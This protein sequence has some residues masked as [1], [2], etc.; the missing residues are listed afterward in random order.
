MKIGQEVSSAQKA[1][2]VLMIFQ[3]TVGL[4][5]TPSLESP[6]SFFK[7]SRPNPQDPSQGPPCLSGIPWKRGTGHSSFFQVLSPGF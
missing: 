6:G 7:K 1:G 3:P 5:T 2:S 4:K